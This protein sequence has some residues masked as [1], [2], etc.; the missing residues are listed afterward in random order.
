MAPTT[1]PADPSSIPGTGVIGEENQSQQITHGPPHT[2]LYPHTY[3]HA[4]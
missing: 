3:I 1:E 2:G 4:I